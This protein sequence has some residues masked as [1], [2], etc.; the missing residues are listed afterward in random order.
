MWF[1]SRNSSSGDAYTDPQV[2]LG[3]T[4]TP[5]PTPGPITLTARGRKVGGINTVRLTWSGANSIN[6]DVYR[7]GVVVVTTVNDGSHIDS[8]G[9]TGRAQY[10]YKVCEA[11]TQTCSNE[12]RVRFRQ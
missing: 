1:D 7:N 8:T 6:I 12:V 2:L 3:S 11:G 4:P 5:T 10:V 9:D